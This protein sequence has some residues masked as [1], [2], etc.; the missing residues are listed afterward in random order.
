LMDSKV[1]QA[2]RVMRPLNAFLAR[3]LC[4]GLN[5]FV[6]RGMLFEAELG[7]TEDEEAAIGPSSAGRLLVPSLLAG[8]AAVAALVAVMACLRDQKAK[9]AINRPPCPL[10][11]PASSGRISIQALQV[12]VEAM[13]GF[14]FGFRNQRF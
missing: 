12:G 5:G 4:V 10:E 9:G 1:L 2:M 11:S 8:V 6:T 7:E 3:H 13:Q 14:C